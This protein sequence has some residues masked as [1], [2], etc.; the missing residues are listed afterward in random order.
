MNQKLLEKLGMTARE[1]KVYLKLLELGSSPANTLAKRLEENRTSTY[2]LLQSLQKKGLVSYSVKRNAKYFFATD[3]SILVDQY[4]HVAKNL[5]LLLPELLAVFNKSA[6]KRRVAFYEGVNGIKQLCET[7]LEVPG[8]TRLSFMGVDE[9]TI[10]PEIKEYFENDFLS[11]RI[12]AG[13]RYRAI[14]T[15]AIP[16]AAG[17]EKKHEAQLRELK[18]VDPK[19]FPMNVQIDIYPHNKVAIY[20]YNKDEMMGIVIEHESFY[21]TMKS[22][23]QIAWMG[24]N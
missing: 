9:A 4:A 23:F 18:W 10:H 8:S 21:T 17:Y 16:F 24:L 2:S 13:I 14:V 3:P 6:N 7:L 11:R 22:I 20:S 5:Q 1:V 19:K 15:G 12:E